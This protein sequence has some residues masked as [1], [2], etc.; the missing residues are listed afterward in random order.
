MSDDEITLKDIE[1]AKKDLRDDNW[2]KCTCNHGKTFFCD[3]YGLVGISDDQVDLIK[4]VT[5]Y[6]E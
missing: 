2:R 5:G 3:K 1:N 4:E 6:E